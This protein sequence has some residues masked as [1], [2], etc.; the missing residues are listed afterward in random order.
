M[1]QTG[2]VFGCPHVSPQAMGV[3][4]LVAGKVA[5]VGVK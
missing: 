1:A 3:L 2:N 5:P 4:Q